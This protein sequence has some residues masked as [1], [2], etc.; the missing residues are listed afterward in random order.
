MWLTPFGGNNSPFW[1]A[2]KLL[3]KAYGF[4][5]GASSMALLDQGL[6]IEYR[7]ES[8]DLFRKLT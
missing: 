7:A 1:Q 2:K 3:A 8:I 4:I 5:S 6:I